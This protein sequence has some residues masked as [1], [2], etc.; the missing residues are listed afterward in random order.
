LP[1]S[2]LIST[3]SPDP[4]VAPLSTVFWADHLS[5]EPDPERICTKSATMPCFVAQQEDL[6]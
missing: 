2:M 6:S 3:V 4:T 5:L 1:F